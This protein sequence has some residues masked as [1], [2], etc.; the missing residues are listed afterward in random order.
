MRILVSRILENAIGSVKEEKSMN[1]K[2][3]KIAKEMI[4][5]GVQ[6]A[7]PQQAIQSQVRVE[8]QVLYVQGDRFSL[9][10]YERVL[11]FAIGKASTPMAGAF[12]QILRPDAG[13]V[14]TKVGDE[15]DLVEVESV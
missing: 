3:R 11:L 9:K 6:A 4:M 7:D 14:I 15:I 10:D 12:E 5:A 1:E 2:F 13:A 8:D